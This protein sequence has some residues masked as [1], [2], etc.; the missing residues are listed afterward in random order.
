MLS[1]PLRGLASDGVASLSPAER[2]AQSELAVVRLLQGSAKAPEDLLWTA[3]D[4]LRL[5]LLSKETAK[6]LCASLGINADTLET[7]LEAG[8][9]ADHGPESPTALVPA[10]GQ[11]GGTAVLS[12][13][14]QQ[15][16]AGAGPSARS[17]SVERPVFGL[18]SL[19]LQSRLTSEFVLLR[20]LGH[21][22]MG[23]VFHAR[24]RLDGAQYAIKI[25]PFFVR[26]NGEPSAVTPEAER[27]LREVQ[28]LSRL[29][30]PNVCRYHN[31]W[32]ET[33]WAS[34]WKGQPAAANGAGPAAG[35]AR[36]PLLLTGAAGEPSADGSL[37]S[38]D[39]T[40]WSQ[41]VESLSGSSFV[42]GAGL[43]ARRDG[44][45]DG[46]G[47]FSFS[48]ESAETVPSLSAASLPAG[49]SLDSGPP[50]EASGMYS[51][52]GAPSVGR[53][54]SYRKALLIQMELCEHATLHD[55]LSA[56]DASLSARGNAGADGIN[57]D[58]S[59]GLLL[60]IASGL[61]HVHACGLV[62]RD[63]KP[64]N[65]CF[66][67]GALKLLDFGLAK[68]HDGLE[69]YAGRG[70][71][72]GYGSEAGS[73]AG[74]PI[75][76][77]GELPILP[78]ELDG[79]GQAAPA[80][81]AGKGTAASAAGKGAAASCL[82]AA[83]EGRGTASGGG[84]PPADWET[85]RRRPAARSR[86]REGAARRA[87]VG[88]GTAGVGTASYSAPEQLEH[89]VARAH[90]DMFSVGL[91]A[92]ELFYPFGSA[93]ERAKH[94][95]HLRAGEVP[96]E[97]VRRWARLSR[98]VSR[99]LS[100][101]P[102]ARPL[103][104]EVLAELLGIRREWEHGKAAYRRQNLAAA[105]S[106]DPIV[107]CFGPPVD[108][109][110]ADEHIVSPLLPPAA[111]Q[112]S[113]LL[114]P[115]LV[116]MA[117]SPEPGSTT[118]ASLPRP[119]AV[120]GAVSPGRREMPHPTALVLSESLANRQRREAAAEAAEAEMVRLRLELAIMAREMRSCESIEMGASRGGHKQAIT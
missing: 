51:A 1:W 112:L 82:T 23:S 99:L 111:G 45:S 91:I 120:N 49:S 86:G 87:R 76:E 32:V 75:V 103:C 60:Q 100:P 11:H 50:V 59:L 22:A 30:H 68:A 66:Q 14:V 2:A 27:V 88:V 54:W 29:N 74:A 118:A 9:V 36:M 41:S 73:P 55:Y 85:V 109:P 40:T 110:L 5:G 33:D 62:H 63:L 116:G 114:S 35:F 24:H 119:C 96:R 67:G 58:E 52:L 80:S 78:P 69:G 15:A 7:L 113:P 70:G 117:V 26:A 18:R 115:V 106:S 89:G 83:S 43:G 81:A 53:R 102:M 25:V 34:L 92:Y 48:P 71:Y 94:F 3:I 98:L 90:C 12:D 42:R 95:G 44:C 28:A 108:E 56:R 38:D 17:P 79:V 31:A 19:G 57:R 107:D 93:M 104:D 6:T 39:G 77:H 4:L 61:E 84:T 46:G 21:G 16:I 10:S 64:A 105:E 37:S 97:F 47:S 72:G 8:A 20:K 101:A 13:M 65:C